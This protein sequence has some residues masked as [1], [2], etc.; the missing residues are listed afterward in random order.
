MIYKLN[1]KHFIYG[2]LY[3]K[4]KDIKIKDLKQVVFY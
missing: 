1:V 4:I 2:R 3:L